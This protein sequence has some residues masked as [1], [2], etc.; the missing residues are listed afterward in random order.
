MLHKRP[1]FGSIFVLEVGVLG[2]KEIHRQGPMDLKIYSLAKK[3]RD[4]TADKIYRFS[5]KIISVTSIS[6]GGGSAHHIHIRHPSL[7][8]GLSQRQRTK[9]KGQSTATAAAGVS[10][11]RSLSVRCKQQQQQWWWRWC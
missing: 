11:L 5:Q 1:S 9:T 7:Q 6:A 3:K 8:P 10:Q 4:T 2:A